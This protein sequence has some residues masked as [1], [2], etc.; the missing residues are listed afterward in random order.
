MRFVCIGLKSRPRMGPVWVEL[1]M[2]S[3]LERSQESIEANQ[4]WYALVRRYE[5]LCGIPQRQ[6]AVLETRCNDTA[7]TG[8]IHRSPGETVETSSILNN[9]LWTTLARTTEVEL[10]PVEEIGGPYLELALVAEGLVEG[11]GD[12]ARGQQR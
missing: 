11:A 12:R 8:C 1:R 9:A 5:D 6:L 10:V 2:M 4:Q 7:G 3:A